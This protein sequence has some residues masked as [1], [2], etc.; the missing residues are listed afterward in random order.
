MA[1]EDTGVDLLKKLQELCGD[2]VPQFKMVRS[3]DKPIVEVSCL[4]L[5]AAG[6]GITSSSAKRNATENLIKLIIKQQDQPM[7]D[8]FEMCEIPDDYVSILFG[9][10]IDKDLPLPQFAEETIEQMDIKELDTNE[11]YGNTKVVIRCC[12]GNIVRCS[13]PCFSTHD[14]R[15]NVAQAMVK[16]LSVVQSSCQGVQMNEFLAED[17]DR[18]QYYMDL[19]LSKQGLKNI[20]GTK[21]TDRH[22]YFVQLDK[23]KLAKAETILEDADEG[24]EKETVWLVCRALGIK[25][26]ME[27][28]THHPGVISWELDTENFDAYYQGPEPQ[29][30][31]RI[32]SYFQ[33]MLR[34]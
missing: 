20:D 12:V 28:L 29:I 11:T 25:F 5:A 7:E 19:Y 3:N 32:V 10:C 15:Q 30:W 26:K 8:M 24:D 1:S 13:D 14:A 17:H 2:N 16:V 9:Y 33:V 21:L 22:N 6:T 31:E 4:G 23:E 18:R 34:K 27:K